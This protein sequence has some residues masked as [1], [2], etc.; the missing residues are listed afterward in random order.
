MNQKKDEREKKKLFLPDVR[1]K[2]LPT[3]GQ[4]GGRCLTHLVG[5]RV[6]YLWQKVLILNT[7]FD[8]HYLKEKLVH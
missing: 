1:S 6:A 7:V 3:I 8:R 2:Q 5:P 4:D